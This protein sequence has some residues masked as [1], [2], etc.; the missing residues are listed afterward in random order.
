M[1]GESTA[2]IC[3]PHC[4]MRMY[5]SGHKVLSPLFK[6]LVATCRNP[7]CLF[8]ARIN[9]EIVKQLQPSLQPRPEIAHDLT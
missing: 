7:D 8:S 6:Q 4:G 3:C 9:I 1:A 2:F 5:T